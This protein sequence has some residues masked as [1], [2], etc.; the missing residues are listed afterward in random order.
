MPATPGQ[1]RRRGSGAHTC[2][3]LAPV[4][5]STSVRSRGN[6]EPEGGS[7]GSRRRVRLGK[8]KA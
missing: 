8:K 6:G 3:Q 1:W 4:S 2:A 5:F 7:S